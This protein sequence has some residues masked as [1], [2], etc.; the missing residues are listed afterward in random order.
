M[1]D[2]SHS[3]KAGRS[4]VG[5]L[6]ED[7][8]CEFLEGR[9]YRIRERNYLKRWGEIDIVGER[10]GEL[11]FFEVKTV[12]DKIPEVERKKIS[13]E[14]Y[15]TYKPEYNVGPEKIKR[16]SRVIGTYLAE[17]NM[18]DRPWSFAVLSVLLNIKDRVAR[19]KFL[20]DIVL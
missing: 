13:R 15:D 10:S 12:S 2:Y 19:V 8:A 4:L 11:F 7:V 18:S 6:G 3:E 20:K 1:I 17:K 9:G 14:N 16:L 5:K